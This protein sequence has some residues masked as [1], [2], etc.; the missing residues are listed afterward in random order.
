MVLL[1]L[2]TFTLASI[3]F[4]LVT[5]ETIQFRLIRQVPVQSSG[6]HAGYEYNSFHGEL[7]YNS[8]RGKED[9]EDQVHQ[10]LLDA[11]VQH[12]A[13]YFSSLGAHAALPDS[14]TNVESSADEA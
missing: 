3:I 1:S 13:R 11:G 2:L 6:Y 10:H 8:Q 9:L 12:G 5:C 7:E 14:T 4:A